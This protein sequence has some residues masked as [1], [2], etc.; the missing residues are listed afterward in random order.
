MTKGDGYWIKIRLPG[1]PAPLNVMLR[2]HYKK[3]NRLNKIWYEAVYLS[4]CR[5]L[6]SKPLNKAYI[7]ATLH[8]ARNLDYDGAVGSLKP[9]ID[10]LVHAKVIRNDSYIVTGSWFVDQEHCK[11]GLEMV[12]IYVSERF[13]RRPAPIPPSSKGTF[14]TGSA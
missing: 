9:L 4:V 13:D 12:E 6:P 1:Q 7:S 8:N 3:R 11:K 5:Q 10:G 14:V 2:M